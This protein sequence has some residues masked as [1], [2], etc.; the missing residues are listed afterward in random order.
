MR[1]IIF[2]IF[3]L[4]SSQT[5]SQIQQYFFVDDVEVVEYVYVDICIGENGET[6]SVTEILDKSTYTNKEVIEQII[7]YRKGFDFHEGSKFSNTC[8]E[9]PFTIVNSKYQSLETVST[10]C[11]LDFGKGKYK[12][13]NPQF[14]NVKIKRRKRKQIEKT[15]D[16]K[17]VYKIEWTSN[18][19]YVLTYLKVSNPKSQYLVGQKMNVKIIDILPNGNYVYYSNLSDRTYG[20]GVMEKL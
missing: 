19:N 4:Q 10:N 17:S 15:K 12:Y 7:E 20:F 9:Y 2:L 18:C 14:Q 5:F 1:K 13:I 3:I 11:K 8:F 16:S 6:I